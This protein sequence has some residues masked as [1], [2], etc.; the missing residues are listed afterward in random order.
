MKT[1]KTR[2]LEKEIVYDLLP[3][4]RKNAITSREIMNLTGF[5]FR[6][7]KQIIT[8][9][10]IDHPICAKETDGGGYWIS[11]KEEDLRDFIKMIE[12]RKAGYESTIFIMR[13]HLFDTRRF[14]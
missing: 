9:L 4:D 2:Q 11:Y 1:Q 14:D 10:R 3:T 5:T 13:E 7:L 12:R 6:K 8:E